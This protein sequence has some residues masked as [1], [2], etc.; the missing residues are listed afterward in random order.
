MHTKYPDTILELFHNLSYNKGD[1]P[2]EVR[3]RG[4]LCVRLGNEDFETPAAVECV[5]KDGDFQRSLE[6]R[7]V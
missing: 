2:S 5:K 4:K 7:Y 3:V 6:N 1:V